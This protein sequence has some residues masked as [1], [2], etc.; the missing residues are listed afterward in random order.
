[1][2]EASNKKVYIPLYFDLMFKKVFGNNK[3]MLP[4]KTLLKYVLDIEPKEV[5]ILNSE[6][7]GSSYYDKG[8]IVDLIVEIEDGT[9]IGIEMNTYVNKYLIQRNLT[10]MFKMMGSNLK[11]GDTYDKLDRHI[12]INFDCEGYHKKPIMRYMLMEEA[13]Q[14]ILSDKLEI[15]RIDIPYYVKKCYNK[16]VSKLNYKEKFIG[17][18]GIRDLEVAKNITEG[19]KD[20]EPIRKTAT[21]FGDDGEL[22]GAYDAEEHRK[23]EERLVMLDKFEQGLEQG[24]EQG[25][26]QGL[27]KGSS[28]KTYSIAKNM[29]KENI[30]I[31]LISK[32]TGLSIE[33]IENLSINE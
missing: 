4:I 12:Q 1:M 19:D 10:Y 18:L 22:L 26:E 14:E 25:I 2:V 27:E 16:D 5:T 20:I 21:V 11:R 23:E 6:I 29:L 9:K 3:D 17:L 15:I 30:D 31:N 8:T 32:V 33:D 24:I 13:T 28:E 7:I